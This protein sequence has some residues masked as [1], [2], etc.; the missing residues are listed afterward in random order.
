MS[1]P[2]L[3]QIDIFPYNF[4]PRGFA[5]CNG[6]ILPISQNT[7]LFSLLGTTYGGNGTTTFALPNL[8]GS[9]PVHFGQGIGLSPYVLGQTGGVASV[10]LTT[11]QLPTHTHSVGCQTAAGGLNSPANAVWG[12]GGRGKPP[13]YSTT[14]SPTA[15]LSGS[16]LGTAGSGQPHNNLSPYL[17][18]SF[19]IA[20]QGIFPS[21]N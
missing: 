10:T 18:L 1:E 5:F 9:V 11:G 13:E 20:L 15:D 6:Q 17:A 2:F 8:Q 12:S 3:G 21:R 16:A 19:C 4:A 7:A 14:S